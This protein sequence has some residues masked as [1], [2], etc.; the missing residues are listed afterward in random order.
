VGAHPRKH[1]PRVERLDDII[2]CPDL[3]ADD[4]IGMI[5]HGRQHDDGHFRSLTHPPAQ[6]EAILPFSARSR[7]TKS[8]VRSANAANISLPPTAT[9]TAWPRLR[10]NAVSKERISLS[11]ST[12]R[13]CGIWLISPLTPIRPRPDVRCAAGLFQEIHIVIRC[14]QTR[15]QTLTLRQLGLPSIVVGEFQWA[16]IFQ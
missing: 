9:L 11:S 1:L 7:I 12:T 16:I 6:A 14:V 10:K 3:R 5:P 2:V 8:T 15:H 4:A 13:M